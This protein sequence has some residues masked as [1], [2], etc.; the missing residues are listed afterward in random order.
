[1]IPSDRFVLPTQAHLVPPRSDVT[2]GQRGGQRVVSDF[3]H[4]WIGAGPPAAITEQDFTRKLLVD[5]KLT[6]LPG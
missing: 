5:G 4:K 1:M 6:S 2:P 3:Q